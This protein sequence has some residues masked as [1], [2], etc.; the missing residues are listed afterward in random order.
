MTLAPELAAVLGGVGGAALSGVVALVLGRSHPRAEQQ[1]GEASA[2]QALIAA[3][4]YHEAQ[5]KQFREDAEAWQREASDWRERFYRGAADLQ[6][7]G[8]AARSSHSLAQQRLE[9]HTP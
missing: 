2:I 7:L 8:S 1:Q 9:G 4:A 5:A 3:A 6:L